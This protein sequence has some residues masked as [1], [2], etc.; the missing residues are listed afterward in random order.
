MFCHMQHIHRLP[1]VRAC[2]P[3]S[4]LRILVSLR[5]RMLARCGRRHLMPSTCSYCCEINHSCRLQRD[6]RRSE[7]K[8]LTSSAP[9][10]LLLRIAL[11]TG[12][13]EAG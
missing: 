12:R 1:L 13:A 8:S 5:G 9:A 2:V 7:D 3:L 11:Q 4:G 10:S 6:M